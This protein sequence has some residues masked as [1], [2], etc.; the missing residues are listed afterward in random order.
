MNWRDRDDWRDLGIVLALAGGIIGALTW[1][2]RYEPVP[3]TRGTGSTGNPA[4]SWSGQTHTIQGSRTPA[5]ATGSAGSFR[6]P[7]P[8]SGTGTLPAP[9]TTA[10]AKARA[11]AVAAW[12]VGMDHK[13]RVNNFKLECEGGV[14]YGQAV[15]PAGFERVE[16]VSAGQGSTCVL[17]Y[18]QP[19]CWGFRQGV[20]A[21]D[22]QEPR[23]LKLEN[24][25]HVWS[26]RG[27][28][29]C[30]LVLD[31]GKLEQEGGDDPGA[32]WCWG[33]GVDAELGK[34]TGRAWADE[35]VMIARKN[36]W[37]AV[38]VGWRTVCA[39]HG[40]VHLTCWGAQ[41][42][43]THSPDGVKLGTDGGWNGIRI[44]RIDEK[45]ERVCGTY[46]DKT[47]SCFG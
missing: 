5:P 18:G 43:G 31:E 35:P 38:K 19:H 11:K 28:T 39:L 8:V 21:T 15:V 44:E 14:R 7:A 13:C 40:Q 37:D 1:G 6:N 47:F 36:D 26:G 33:E 29:N 45:R 46:R 42:D 4:R 10:P 20:G 41:P 24:A 16:A 12:E 2:V 32:L 3:A 23:A 27:G 9:A 34:I 22:T 25:D 30:A 17:R